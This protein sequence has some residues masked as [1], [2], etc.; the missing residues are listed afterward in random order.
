MWEFLKNLKS[1]LS[2]D[3]RSIFIVACTSWCVVLIPEH[4]WNYLGLIGLRTTIKPWAS[5]IGVLFTLWLIF[6]VL[7]DLFSKGSDELKAW[8]EPRKMQKTREEI[9]LSTS[10]VE[11]QVLAKYITENTTTI[12]FDAR[13]GV[14]NGLIKKGLLYN[15]SQASNPMSFNFDVNMQPWAWDY[16]R[17]HPEMLKDSEPLDRG[18]HQIN[19]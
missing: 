11:K 13:D 1:F 8:N 17:A 12:A 14:V 6:G 9:L 16:L 2:L 5:I 18:R 15:A 4:S 3:Y 10:S 7:Y 19:F